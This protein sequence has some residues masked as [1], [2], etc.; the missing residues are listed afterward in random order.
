MQQNNEIKTSLINNLKGCLN[1]LRDNEGLTGD[2]GLTG[3]VFKQI[4]Q[5]IIEFYYNDLK[6]DT[7]Y[8]PLVINKI[9]C[10]CSKKRIQKNTNLIKVGSNQN[11]LEYQT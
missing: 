8:H 6:I 9:K 3:D 7:P 4:E 10:F 1:I 2:K 11:P 5:E